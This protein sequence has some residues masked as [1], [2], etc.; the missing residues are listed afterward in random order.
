MNFFSRNE[1]GAVSAQESPPTT[2]NNLPI[3]DGDNS[4][5]ISDSD[6]VIDEEPDGEDITVESDSESQESLPSAHRSNRKPRKKV[7][8]E[9]PRRSRRFV[10]SWLKDQRFKKWLQKSSNGKAFCKFCHCEL[11][12][13]IDALLDHQKTPKHMKRLDDFAQLKDVRPLTE[14]VSV[15][16]DS[17]KSIE[18]KIAVF[19]AEHCSLQTVDHL[20]ELINTFPIPKTKFELK[21]STHS[22]YQSIVLNTCC[23]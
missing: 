10:S 9:E 17:T 23:F 11:R 13:K 6:I 12:N 8:D 4:A 22:L 5:E 19:I 7:T 16:S 1:E 20:S 14:S 2:E 15:V 18:L 21:V 3:S